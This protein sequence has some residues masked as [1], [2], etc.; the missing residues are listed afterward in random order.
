MA[1]LPDWRKRTVLSIQNRRPPAEVAVADLRVC[2]QSPVFV[3]NQTGWRDQTN[4]E[5]LVP[6]FRFDPA[7]IH[8]FTGATRQ[9]LNL[10]IDQLGT[11]FFSG[12]WRFGTGRIHELSLSFG[13]FR[14]TP[15]K[16]DWFTVKIYVTAEDLHWT[17]NM[18]VD[19]T[20]LAGFVEGLSAEGFCSL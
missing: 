15:S 2:F 6:N 9:W 17:D 5:I 1:E 4:A 3:D 19:Y 14:D 13:P 12:E 10:P 16:T 18:H 20:G 8:D 11:K 7:A